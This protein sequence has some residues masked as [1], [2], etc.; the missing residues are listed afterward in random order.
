MGRQVLPVGREAHLVDREAL[1]VG[2]VWSGSL[3]GGPRVVG[4]PSRWIGWP[5]RLVG[6][7]LEALLDG[8]S[9]WETLPEGWKWSGVPSG[10]PRV[11]G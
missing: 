10:G 5:S 11:V 3:P 4:R 2:R 1:Q 7:G 6:S 8:R 9:G